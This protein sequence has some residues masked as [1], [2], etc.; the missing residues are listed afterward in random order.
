MQMQSM[1]TKTTSGKLHEYQTTRHF[2]NIILEIE[3]WAFAV[4]LSKEQNSSL[5]SSSAE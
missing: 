1:T 4:L 2:S 5:S 3:F